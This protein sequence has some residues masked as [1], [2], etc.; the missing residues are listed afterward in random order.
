MPETNFF[1]D[2]LSD[3]ILQERDE[4]GAVTAAYTTEP[5]LHGN[6]IS[7]NRSGVESQFHFDAL[8]STLAVTDDNQQVTATRAH[9]AFGE[10][11]ESI[12]N[13]TFPFQYIGQKGYYQSGVAGN[14]KVRLKKH[15]KAQG[16]G[17]DDLDSLW[18]AGQTYGD[19]RCQF[20]PQDLVSTNDPAKAQFFAHTGLEK[21]GHR[22]IFMNWTCC[23][24]KEETVFSC[25]VPDPGAEGCQTLS[26]KRQK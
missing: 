11:T 2:P 1:W 10:T 21:Q 4:A 3:N 22:T 12:G 20:T 17:T 13:D 25:A 8:G 19:G 16:V 5:G 18:T 15:A 9:S 6:V 23:P 26:P 14:Y 7:Q 24:C